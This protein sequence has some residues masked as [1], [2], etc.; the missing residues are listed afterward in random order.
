[1]LLAA[2]HRDVSQAPP[3]KKCLVVDL[4]SV[5]V[6][7]LLPVLAGIWCATDSWEFWHYYVIWSVALTLTTAVLFI[8]ADLFIGLLSVG[9]GST[10]GDAM[11]AF[12]LIC[13]T[14]DKHKI[15]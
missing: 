15:Y 10:A 4:W 3:W 9:T 13:E 14:V 6:L 7:E 11:E 1:M 12:Y 8:V 2:L 5:P